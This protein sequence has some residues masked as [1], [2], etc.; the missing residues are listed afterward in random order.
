MNTRYYVGIDYSM[1]SPAICIYDKENG[2]FKYTNTVC[3][4][5]ASK[6]M[7]EGL[8]TP[9]LIATDY[10]IWTREEERYELLCNW[11]LDC[12]KNL[13]PEQTTIT[14]EG[15]SFG[16]TG[17]VFNIAEN[18]GVLKQG[19]YRMGY[20]IDVVPPTTIKK[21]ATGKGNANKEKMYEA[22]VKENPNSNLLGLLAH[23][24]NVS[25]ISPLS[26]IVDAYF[27]CKS[28]V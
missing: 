12:I 13:P 25:I 20:K 17:K 21:F 10:P 1:T 9:N 23:R 2:K 7:H 26:D 18:T 28:A 6:R 16:S 22:F 11:V 14:L 27:L 5:L 8:K 24:A 3:H 4:F 15:Y 19:L